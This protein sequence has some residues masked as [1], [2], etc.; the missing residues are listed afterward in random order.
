[1]TIV[2]YK[3]LIL[4]WNERADPRRDAISFPMDTHSKCKEETGHEK[5]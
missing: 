2:D 3:A 4:R 5:A 1:M